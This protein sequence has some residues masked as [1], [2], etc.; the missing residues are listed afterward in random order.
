MADDGA[1]SA[2]FE[3]HRAHLLGVAY[4]TLGS[5]TDAEDVVQEA[6]LRLARLEDPEVIED[7]RGWLTRVTGRLALD[8]LRRAHRHREQY[9]GEWLP[10]PVV[11]SDRLDP[12][13][14]V[15]LDESVTM[16]LLMVLERLSPAERTA[17]VLH[18]VFGMPFEDVG[19]VVGR[20]PAAVR[21]LAA[22]ARSHVERTRPR[23]PAGRDEHRRIVEAFA[24][25]SAEGNLEAL[26]A[27]LDE[28]VVWHSDG[29]GHVNALRHPLRG[30]ERV[31][32]AVLGFARRPPR[33][34]EIALVNG[35]AGVVMRDADGLL[36]VVSFTIDDGQIVGLQSMRNPEK[37]ARVRL[38]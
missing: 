21:Q 10:E 26:V 17:F 24:L 2:A 29:G 20:S 38:P 15:T 7:L 1:L 36:T 32:K 35:K 12:A 4:S 25:A 31:A 22:R 16:A 3:A 34:A 18:D 11:G 13:D 5:M 37:L 33:S 30:R 19:E 14:Q 6:W 8:A 27:T 23:R 28:E 9:V